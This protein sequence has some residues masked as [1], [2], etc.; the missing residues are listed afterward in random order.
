MDKATQGIKF[1]SDGKTPEK[2]NKSDEEEQAITFQY[3]TDY[4][5]SEEDSN[6]S[7]EESEEESYIH[8]NEENDKKSKC[9][10]FEQSKFDRD[11]FGSDEEEDEKEFAGILLVGYTKEDYLKPVPPQKPFCEL[12]NLPI[13][14]DECPNHEWHSYMRKDKI[15]FPENRGWLHLL[16]EEREMTKHGIV[17]IVKKTRALSPT[18]VLDKKKSTHNLSIKL[19]RSSR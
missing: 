8:I 1:E 11:W 5:E 19:D 7:D 13:H 15:K 6:T 2:E 18:G 3:V 4:E 10:K 14:P 12:S 16:E 9:S 17:D